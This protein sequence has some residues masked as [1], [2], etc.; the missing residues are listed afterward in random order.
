MNQ[1]KLL[2]SLGGG[3]LIIGSILPWAKI[4]GINLTA[5]KA[6]YEGDGIFTGGIGLLLLIGAI[7]SKAK[8]GKP[9]SIASAIFA[10]IAGV[11]ILLDLSDVLGFVSGV[12]D[13]VIAKVGAGMY[14]SLI[15]AILALIGGFQ[16]IPLL[17][18]P[19]QSQEVPPP[20]INP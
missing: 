16:K 15:G 20:I 14:V 13:N 6:G 12:G 10:I 2:C 7:V 17:P 11:I 4:I 8:P 3:C 18:Q 5:S 1:G 19:A 9:F